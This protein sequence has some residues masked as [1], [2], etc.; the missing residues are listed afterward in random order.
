E[1]QNA[2]RWL[3]IRERRWQERQATLTTDGSAE[4]VAE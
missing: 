2:R 3:A 1:A 4:P